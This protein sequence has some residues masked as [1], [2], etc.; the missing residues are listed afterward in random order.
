MGPLGGAA[1]VAQGRLAD[2]ADSCWAV[3]KARVLPL[4]RDTVLPVA[5]HTADRVASLLLPDGVM[6]QLRA[7]AARLQPHV[8]Y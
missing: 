3:A 2:W 8:R 4:A 7:Q 5:L 6:R 1:L